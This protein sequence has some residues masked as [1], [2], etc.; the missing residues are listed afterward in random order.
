[1]IYLP[2]LAALIENDEGE[3]LLAKRREDLANGGTW[4]FPGGKLHFD[5]SPETGLI[6]EIKEELG[7]EIEVKYPFHTVSHRDGERVILL[8]SYCCRLISDQFHLLDHTEI[9]W[10]QPE[11]MPALPVSPADVEIVRKL[12]SQHSVR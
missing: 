4:E 5:E 10:V 6:R 2:V 12:Q 3:I 11:Q 7:V 1:M 8:M 9:R